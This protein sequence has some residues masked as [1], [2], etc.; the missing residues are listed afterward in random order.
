VTQSYPTTALPSDLS[1]Y[2][3][4]TTR[5]GDDA[6]PLPARIKLARAAMSSGVYFHTSEQYGDA[7][8]VLGRAFAEAKGEI[9]KLTVKL[10]NDSVDELRQCVLRHLRALG[11][12]RVHVGQLCLG[13]ALAEDFASGGQCYDGLRQL[14][15]EG[16]VEHYFLEIFPW[17][18]QLPQQ[19]LEA[20]HPDGLVGGC[21]FYYNPLQRFASNPLWD[22]LLARG[23]PIIAMRTVAGGDVK[24]LRDVP[25]AAW[26]PYLQERAAE[27]APIFEGSGI[28]SWSEFCVRFAHSCPL[29]RATVGATSRTERLQEFLD[30]AAEPIEPLPQDIT[31]EISNLQR[32]WSDETDVHAEPWS[33]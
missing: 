9:P 2:V 29:V 1:K 15:Q 23:V 12:D 16:L 33:M 32:R 3:Y 4:G 19:A 6:I 17:T 22:V 10:G 5:L 31:D 26:K 24:R 13:S 18:S 25:G 28:D 8:S 7:L 30:A 20:A 11:V 21:I 14:Q 27:V